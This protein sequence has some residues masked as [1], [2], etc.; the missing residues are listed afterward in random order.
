MSKTT[1]K[2]KCNG[3]TIGVRADWDQGSAIVES[4]HD[5][6][7]FPTQNNVSFFLHNWRNALENELYLF[8][9]Y[10]DGS[11]QTEIEEALAQAEEEEK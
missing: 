3:E 9:A 11:C 10:D 7:W 5:G 8:F 2:T 4:W 6:E 1:Y